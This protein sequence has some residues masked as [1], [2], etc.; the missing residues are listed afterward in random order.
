MQFNQV[1][2]NPA[3]LFFLFFLFLFSSVKMNAQYK[4]LD[5]DEETYRSEFS[6]GLKTIF[7]NM[8]YGKTAEL[9]DMTSIG[10][11]PTV[12]YDKPIKLF[13]I[14]D[15]TSYINV[16]VSTGIAY[17]GGYA[18]IY[19]TDPITYNEKVT[20]TKHPIYLPVYVGIYSGAKFGIGVEAF[21]AKGFNQAVDI[22]G[23]K[24]LS[25]GY[26]GKKFRVGLA[27]EIYGCKDA[28]GETYMDSFGSFEFLWKL[29]RKTE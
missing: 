7:G 12:R 21:Y 6:V 18:E 22:Y 3:K 8:V 10:V 13:T 26:N 14:N 27:Y 11:Q 15:K 28:Y 23:F 9:A 16:S 29:K 24:A 19:T 1:V 17:I 20:K 5:D 25:L 2:L 4:D